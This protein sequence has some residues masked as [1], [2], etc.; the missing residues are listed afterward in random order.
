M[1]LQDS[2]KPWLGK[3]TSEKAMNHWGLSEH[4][5]KKVRSL[6]SGILKR[7]VLARAFY[8]DSD[9]LL[10][11][12]PFVGL[13]LEYREI[14]L[15]CMLSRLQQGS[16]IIFTGHHVELGNNFHPKTLDMEFAK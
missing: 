14:L 5:K 12:E 4:A 6:S 3:G 1:S 15:G 2:L 9:I 10:L 7:A 13:D 8:L 11:D 16:T